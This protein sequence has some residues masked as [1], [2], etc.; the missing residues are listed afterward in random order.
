MEIIFYIIFALIAIVLLPEIIITI[1]SVTT[2]FIVLI[3]K[4]VYYLANKIKELCQK[5]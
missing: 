3:V 2:L 4:C 5:N 1:L